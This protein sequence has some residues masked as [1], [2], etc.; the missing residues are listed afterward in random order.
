[1]LLKKLIKNLDIVKVVGKLN[2]EI[3]DIVENSGKSCNGSLFVCLAGKDQDGHEFVGQ[4][5][6]YGAVAVLTEKQV[7]VSVPQVI[8]KDTRKALSIVAAEFFGRA[9]KKLKMVGVVGTNG[10]T[11]TARFIA[12]IL[13]G[14]GISTGVIGTLGT[15]YNDKYIE[16]TLTTP[17]PLVLH[18]TLKD[19]YDDGVKVVV[20]EVSAHAIYWQKIN[21]IKFSV[22]VFTN[23][24]RD[25]LDFF[26]DYSEYKKTKMDFFK[27]FTPDFIVTNSDDLTGREIAAV[28][29][30]AITYG[31]DNPADVFAIEINSNTNG[32]GFVMNLFDCIYQIQTPLIGKFNVQNVLAASTVSA[33]LGVKTE[34]IAKSVAKLTAVKGRMEKI[35]D[36]DFSVYVD[37][38]HTPDGL[39]QCLRSLKPY[40]KGKL[41]NVFGCGGNRDVGKRQQMGEVSATFADFSV[42][43]SDN[44]RFEDPMTII[45]QIESGFIGKSKNYA[46]IEWRE[47]GIRYAINLAKKGDVVLIAGKGAEEYQDI[48]GI[49]K[50]Y[51][52]KDTVIEILRDKLL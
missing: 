46:L 47:D 40:C 21:G 42:I 13:N 7:D 16:P 50:P 33:L 43:T 14:N 10:K 9:D 39:T 19:M 41:I 34:N 36:G 22:G 28:I 15:F 5:V 18:K 37:Y 32:T 23:L 30:N 6:N 48:L 1:M 11:S 3:A 44:P 25:H 2:V 8:V 20:M 52:D 26:N 17:D 38:A 35:Y 24:T 12:D 45:R 49:K 29:D 27:K 51:N 31:V 4:A